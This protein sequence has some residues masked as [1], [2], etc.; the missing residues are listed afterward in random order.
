MPQWFVDCG[1]MAKRAVDNVRSGAMTIEP[2]SHAHTWFYFL[3]NIQDWCVSRQ[4]WWGHRIPAYRVKTDRLASA[5]KSDSSEQW[6]VARSVTEAREKAQ[7]ELGIELCDSDLEQDV[8]V[9]D[10]WFSSGLLPLS[11]LVCWSTLDTWAMHACIELTT[12]FV[13]KHTTGVAASRGREH[14][15]CSICGEL[16]IE[17]DGNRLRHFVFLGRTDGDAL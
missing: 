16:S 1:S 17:R 12:L 8:D 15:C 3:E 6:F 2:K 5:G 13:L 11:A 4:L 9:L 10:T 14:C 7:S